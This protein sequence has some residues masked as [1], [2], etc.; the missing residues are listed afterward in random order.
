MRN[1]IKYISIVGISFFIFKCANQLPPPG[2]PVDKIPPQVLDVYPSDST[3]NFND[4]HFEIEFSEYV[5]KLSLMDAL[6]ISP[7][8]KKLEYDWSGTS[9]E[10]TFDDTLKENT[11]Y[12]VSIGSGIQDLNNRNNMAQAVNFA[13]STGPNIDVGKIS[14]KVYDNDPNGIMIFAYMEKDSFDNPIIT[15]PKNVSQVG[16]NGEFQ[17]LGLANGNFRVFAIKEEN[18]NRLYNIGDDWYGVPYEDISLSDSSLVVGGLTFRLTKEDTIAPYISNVAMTDRN[19]ILLEYSENIDSAKI[20]GDNF[21]IIDSVTQKVTHINYF[22]QPNKNKSEYF[23]TIAD[24]FSQE[25]NYFV[26]AKNIFDNYG[27]ESVIDS[28]QFTISSALDTL[29]PSFKKID[30]GFEQNKLDYLNPEFRL[31]FSDGINSENLSD[32]ISITH[33]DKLFN[34]DVIRIDDAQFQI[35]ILNTLK[36]EEKLELNIDNLK[37]WDTAENKLDTV[38]TVEIETL[39]GREFSGVS[40]TIDLS[41]TDQKVEVVLEGIEKLNTKYYTSV[42]S[43]HS[44][45]FERVLPGKYLIWCFFDKDSNGVF[46]YGSINPFEYSERFYSYPDTLNLRARWPVGDVNITN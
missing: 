38:K 40:G 26:V 4:D 21:F 5:E 14:G 16:E 37:L 46:N 27:N 33:K 22:F 17:S 10:I 1:L 6:F 24:S 39:S 18:K 44:F 23:I 8:I 28:Y 34:F 25:G 20:N 35:K 7:E 19:H 30:T 15:K 9:V 3:L 2:G 41:Q 29:A 31:S 42:M 32:V 12:T 13:F 45:E 43:D 11:T 36:P